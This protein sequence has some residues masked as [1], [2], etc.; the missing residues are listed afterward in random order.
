MRGENVEEIM[1]QRNLGGYH[2]V[3]RQKKEHAGEKVVYLVRRDKPEHA[4]QRKTGQGQEK[5]R[6]RA[7]TVKQD[8]VH[9]TGGDHAQK[10]EHDKYYRALVTEPVTVFHRQKLKWNQQLNTALHNYPDQNQHPDGLVAVD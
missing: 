2:A 10:L 4:Y 3:A 5:N 9:V 8:R 7:R 6:P 1:R